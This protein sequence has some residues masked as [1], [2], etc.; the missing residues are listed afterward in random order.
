MCWPNSV[1]TPSILPSKY[2]KLLSH[3]ATQ[4]DTLRQWSKF[5]GNSVGRLQAWFSAQQAL[6]EQVQEQNLCESL[7]KPVEHVRP[8]STQKPQ[9]VLLQVH[10]AS[11]ARYEVGLV[12]SIFRGAVEQSRGGV[13][14]RSQVTKALA[15]T[16]PINAVKLVHVCL[17]EHLKDGAWFTSATSQVWHLEPV[18]AI[19]GEV[20][21]KMDLGEEKQFFQF[22]ADTARILRKW[23]SGKLPVDMG[24]CK[25]AESQALCPDKATAKAFTRFSFPKSAAGRENMQTFLSQL[26]QHYLKAGLAIL[27]REGAIRIQQGKVEWT[28]V[29]LRAPDYF[30]IVTAQ[31]KTKDSSLLVFQKLKDLLP[32]PDRALEQFI[33]LCVLYRLITARYCVLSGCNMV[34]I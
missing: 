30:D 27:D 25:P 21:P 6:A 3:W 8:L 29:V 20:F 1:Q 23:Q 14:R 22:D 10:Q 28:S 26:P 24:A 12:L 11:I 13:A 4:T 9:V 19:C 7:V 31:D 5:A 2:D 32:E 17:L 34:M 18:G 33:L 16:A 15:G